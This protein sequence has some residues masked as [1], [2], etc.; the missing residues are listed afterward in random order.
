[1]GPCTSMSIVVSDCY[2][3]RRANLRMAKCVRFGGGALEEGQFLA[4]VNDNA[5]E[6]GE[7]GDKIS[8]ISR[9]NSPV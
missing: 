3:D 5:Y 9:S 7:N 4:Q 6:S 2:R 1:M 8:S